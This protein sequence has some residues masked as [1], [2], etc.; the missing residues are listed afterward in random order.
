MGHMDVYKR[1]IIFFASVKYLFLLF[2]TILYHGVS[3]AQLGGSSIYRFMNLPNSARV[4]AM[5]GVINAIQDE[6]VNLGYLNPALFNPS[7]HNRLSMNF[8]DYF[9]GV[10]YGFAGYARDVEGLGTFGGGLHYVNYGNFKRTDFTGEVLGEFTAGEYCL[11]IGGSRRMDSLFTVGAQFKSIFSHFAEYNSFGLAL[12]LGAHY[13][14]L[15]KLTQ[16]SIVVR[17]FGYQLATY[18]PDTRESMPLEIQAGFAKSFEHLPLKISIVAHNLQQPDLTFRDP[19]VPIL[20]NDPLTGDTIIQRRQIGD[21]IMRHII[22][23]A[24]LNLTKNI[25]FRIGYNYMRRQEMKVDTRIGTVGISWGLGLNL[26]KFRLDYGRSA[27][28][29]AGSPN[30]LSL[31]FNLSEFNSR[32]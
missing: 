4:Q 2:I 28:H 29:L 23:G 6:D 25:A 12:D 18:S 9:G 3:F 22:L 26:R 14:S 16:L 20:T 1:K 32:N 24:E 21:K 5:G 15:D 7:M 30:N 8:V 10:N 31:T 27:Y 13:R 17:N 11:A 19:S